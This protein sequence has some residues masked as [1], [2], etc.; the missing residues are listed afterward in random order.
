MESGATSAL[1]EG[2]RGGKETL[3]GHIDSFSHPPLV[4][5]TAVAGSQDEQRLENDAGGIM[6]FPRFKPASYYEKVL[7]I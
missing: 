4:G 3:P 6:S 2:T 7:G 1:R 5:W